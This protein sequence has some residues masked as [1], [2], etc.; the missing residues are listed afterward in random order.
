MVSLFM[1]DSQQDES[2]NNS[3]STES[4]PTDTEPA[5][6][7]T[8]NLKILQTN[9]SK[10]KSFTKEFLGLFLFFPAYLLFSFGAF[11]V[12]FGGVFFGG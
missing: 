9:S 3:I 4:N 10:N 2:V 7:P 5:N 8:P 12:I 11:Y 1:Q 6:E